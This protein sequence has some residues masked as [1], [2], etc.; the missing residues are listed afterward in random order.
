MAPDLTILEHLNAA[1]E[2]SRGARKA[3]LAGDI[4]ACTGAIGRAKQHMKEVSGA[5]SG[6]PESRDTL[7]KPIQELLRE[8]RD[9]NQLC[10]P[11][12]AGN[13][14]AVLSGVAERLQVLK[15]GQR[16]GPRA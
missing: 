7:G 10:A 6:L 4:A 14:M 15:A 11:E 5:M 16:H 12:N 2:A 3:V 9:A 1:I 8:L 13:G